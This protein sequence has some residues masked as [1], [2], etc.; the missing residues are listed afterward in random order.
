MEV[1]LLEDQGMS[2]GQAV[3]S[4]LWKITVVV[5]QTWDGMSEE[6]LVRC[7][8]RVKPDQLAGD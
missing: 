5:Q 4:L 1:T 7:I 2:P 6:R 3:A 8:L